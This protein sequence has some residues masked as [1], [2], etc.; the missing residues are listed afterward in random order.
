M[1]KAALAAAAEHRASITV[2]AAGAEATVAVVERM[3]VLPDFL[4]EAAA[5]ILTAAPTR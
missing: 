2:V 5:D 1:L 3:A 4:N